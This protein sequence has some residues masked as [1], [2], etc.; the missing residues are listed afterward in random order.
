MR[1]IEYDSYYVCSVI[2]ADENEQSFF[3]SEFLKVFHWKLKWFG[4][5]PHEEES[6]FGIYCHDCTCDSEDKQNIITFS[7]T[8]GWSDKITKSEHLA[9][10]SF[11]NCVDFNS[12]Y[13]DRNNHL[14]EFIKSKKLENH[15]EENC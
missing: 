6:D 2:F 1:V 12:D 3:K 11:R 14:K 9:F 13:Y 4:I 7:C 8:C 5:D 15:R 10:Q